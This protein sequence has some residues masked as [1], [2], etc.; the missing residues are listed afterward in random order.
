M[1]HHH[2]HEHDRH[3]HENKF[4]LGIIL[5]LTAGY[6]IAEFFGGIFTNSLA[7]LAD[8]G[9]MLSDVAALSLSFFAI[10]LSLKPASPT[11]TYGFYR[12]EILAA[13][14]NGV[15]LVGI[16]VFII[17]EAYQRIFTLP[18][19]KAPLMIAIAIG[20]LIIN[21]IGV[22]L[23]HGSS[24]ENLNIKGAFLHIIG[25]LLGSIGTII[26]GF[27]ILIWN[28]NLADPII[29][30]IIAALI[31]ISAIRLVI[32]ATNVLL[33]ATPSHINVESIK[34]AI[35]EIP[36]VE[37]VHDLHVW[38]ISS[39]NIALSV[40]VVSASANCGPILC[41]I[42]GLIKEK[43]GINHSTIQIEPKE[44]HEG[45]CCF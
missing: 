24:K 9:H 36:L 3:D 10:W 28:F 18:E 30:F 40:H 35:L 2:N 17:Y 45:K 34:E 39:K 26:A 4:K 33:E 20:G 25:D 31:L 12:T 5:F 16:A 8:A 44:F 29:S 19:I 21:I 22:L 13:L 42:D 37:D 41:T 6:M 43:F 27:I 32:E 38:S 1:E 15:A 11:R 7:L 14:I 23:L